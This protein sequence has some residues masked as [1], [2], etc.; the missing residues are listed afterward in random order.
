MR[1]DLIIPDEGEEKAAEGV[2]TRVVTVPFT[3]LV[4]RLAEEKPQL[5]PGLERL[6]SG[7]GEKKFQKYINTIHNINL[8]GSHMLIVADTEFHRTMLERECLEE[9]RTAFQVDN[10]RIVAQG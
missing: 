3:P 10:I 5:L 2:A 4:A 8:S 1:A 9:I 7:L 6:Q